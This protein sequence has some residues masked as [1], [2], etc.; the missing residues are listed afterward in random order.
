MQGVPTHD[1]SGEPLSKSRRKKL[2]KQL[3]KHEKAHNRF[4]ART[5]TTS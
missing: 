2:A 1:G 5:T 3:R 4:M